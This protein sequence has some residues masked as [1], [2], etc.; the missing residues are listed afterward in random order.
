MTTGA[1]HARHRGSGFTL[2]EIMVALAIL[3]LTLVVLLSIVTNNVRATNHAKMTTAATLLARSKMV[4]IEDDI[5][6]NG[7]SNDNEDETG[8]FK[9][10]GYPQFRWESAIDRIELPT[11]LGQKAKDQA[12]EKTQNAKDPMS[13]VSGFMGGMM[14]SFLEPVRIGLEESVRKV[15]VRVFWDE[16]GRADQ[17][18]EVVQY[19]T[20]PAKL[21]AVF[22]GGGAAGAAGTPGQPT[23]PGAGAAKAGA[24]GA[25]AIKLPGQL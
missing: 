19:L 9:E 1:H 17:T 18:L 12:T 6:Y 21:D 13:M 8:T 5:L 20:D 22:Q 24:L 7:F 11:D 10:Q 15:T 2:L 23:A 16:V 3:G 25:P 4:D 14:S